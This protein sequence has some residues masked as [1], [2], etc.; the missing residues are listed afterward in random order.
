MLIFSKTLLALGAVNTLRLVQSPVAEINT[1]QNPDTA[2]QASNYPAIE[3]LVTYMYTK[4]KSQ[5]VA[6]DCIHN[7]P[8]WV[9][10]WAC[11]RGPT[12]QLLGQYSVDG[13]EF[14]SNANLRVVKSIF[15]EKY[16]IACPSK[17]VLPRQERPMQPSPR[18]LEAEPWR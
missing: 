6:S 15:S 2:P 3:P 7:L 16:P 13:G 9:G 18:S 4:G 11:P 12:T 17:G 1:G 14:E 5:N 10:C 8:S